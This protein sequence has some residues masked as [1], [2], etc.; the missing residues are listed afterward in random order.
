MIGVIFNVIFPAWLIVIF[1]CV[2]LGAISL[3]TVIKVSFGFCNWDFWSLLQALHFWKKDDSYN[4]ISQRSVTEEV[5]EDEAIPGSELFIEL[6]SRIVLIAGYCWP[7]TRTKSAYSLE[8]SRR[9]SFCLGGHLCHS[10]NQRY[11]SY[12]TAWTQ[13]RDEL[14]M[15]VVGQWLLLHNVEHESVWVVDNFI[16]GLN[17]SKRVPSIFGYFQRLLSLS[18]QL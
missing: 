14:E 3:R 18:S 9:F 8:E 15:V 10:H 5:A 2:A 12:L 11:L 16:Q 6:G 13:S 4:P 7:V 17:T 1:L